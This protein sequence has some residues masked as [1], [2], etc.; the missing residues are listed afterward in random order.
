MYI[1]VHS[2]MY[3]VQFINFSLIL[4]IK[5]V[6]LCLHGGRMNNSVMMKKSVEGKHRGSQGRIEEI[7]ST[8]CFA[9]PSSGAV[10]E[11]GRRKRKRE[12]EECHDP[13]EEWNDSIW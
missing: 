11:A 3:I 9:Y 4:M 5:D 10:V 7:L 12:S 8:P 6:W 2:G 13:L 1:P